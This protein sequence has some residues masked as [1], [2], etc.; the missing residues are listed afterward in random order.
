M[1]FWISQDLN[2]ADIQESLMARTHCACGR[3]GHESVHLELYPISQHYTALPRARCFGDTGDSHKN[4][5]SAL[6]GVSA[7]YILFDIR[8][9]PWSWLKKSIQFMIMS[10]AQFLYLAPK[11]GH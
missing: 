9:I 10:V 1:F 7:L 4:Q 5:I 6:L 8:H 11:L 2:A 3:G